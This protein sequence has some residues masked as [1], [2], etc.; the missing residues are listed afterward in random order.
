MGD[1]AQLKPVMGEV[2]YSEGLETSTKPAIVRGCRGKRQMQYT[3]TASGQELYRKYLVTNCVL[4]NRG[5]HS[6]G[7]WQQICDRLP[8][9]QQT[10]D[11][12][13]K[14]STAQFSEFQD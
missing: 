2:I 12:L 1:S 6:S 4:L 7:L 8:G 14:L 10:A 13:E 9:G 11:D 5:Q 3:L